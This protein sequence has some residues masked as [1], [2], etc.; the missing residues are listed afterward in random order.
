MVLATASDVEDRLRRYL[1]DD[2]SEYVDVLLEEASVLVVGWLSQRGV[3]VDEGDIPRA[4]VIAVSRMVARAITTPANPNIPEGA[5]QLNAG[6][7][8]VRYSDPY[9]TS[10]FLSKSDMVLLRTLTPGVASLRLVSERYS[11]D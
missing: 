6:P 1:T 10:V 9:S 11:D 2:E 3:T 4:A 7:F 5:S 8:G